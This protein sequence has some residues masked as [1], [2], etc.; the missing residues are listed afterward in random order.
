[1]INTS[2]RRFSFVTGINENY[3]MLACQLADSLDRYFPLNPLFVMDFGLTEGQQEFFRRRGM[4][5]PMPPGLSKGMHPYTFK[6]ASG[7]Y[8]SPE[9]GTPVWIDADMIA[10]SNGT[11]AL[12][13]LIENMQVLDQRFAI[14]AANAGDLSIA[15]FIN[16]WSPKRFEDAL[17]GLPGVASRPYLSAGLIAFRQSD[18]L[19]DWRELS[20]GF[21]G[22]ACWEQNALNVLCYRQPERVQMIDTRVWNV[23][24]TLYDALEVGEAGVYCGG[25]QSIFLHLASQS[26]LHIELGQANFTF[27]QFNYRNFFKFFVHPALRREQ[28]RFIEEFVA[29]HLGEMRELGMIS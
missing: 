24:G 10:V 4:L 22:E 15:Q 1:M 18:P 19:T 28:A 12:A 5:L 6:S 11:Q 17:A 25:L 16:E 27:G 20:T 9:L 7:S 14:S 21:E 23:H 2:R 13:D 29:A 3:F 26:P 8:F